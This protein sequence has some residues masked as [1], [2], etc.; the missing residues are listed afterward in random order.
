MRRRIGFGKVWCRA[1]WAALCLLAWSAAAGAKTRESALQVAVTI[2]PQKWLV[3]QVGG[4][5]ATVTALVA[6]G[7]SPATYLP[8]DAQ[9]SR[10]M[11]SAVYFRIGV[12][13]ENGS[14]LDALL[15]SGR[16]EIVDLRDGVELLDMSEHAEHDEAD[17]HSHAGDDP[18]TWLSPSRLKLQAR[19]IAASL[20][21]LDPEG[22]EHY[23]RRLA[24]L[25]RRL[26]DLDAEMHGL[27]AAFAG[28]SFLV[29][30]PS[31]GYLAADYGLRQLTLEI[32]GKEPSE[33]EITELQALA[34]AEGI[35]V[36]FVQPQITGRAAS[37]VASAIDGRTEV[38][39]PLAA[40][41]AANLRQAALRIASSFDPAGSP[42]TEGDGAQ[43]PPSSTHT[44]AS[45]I[46]TSAP[47]ARRGVG[48][49]AF[50]RDAAGNPFLL[51]GL[52]AGLLASLAC[53]IVGPYVVTRR[54]V[55]LGG[56]IAHI[57]VGGLGATI[58]LQFEA[59]EAF[60]GLR[61]LYGA[62]LVAVLAALLLARLE[63]GAERRTGGDRPVAT[64]TVIGALWAA[65]MAI[66]ILLIKLTPGYHTELMSYLFGNLA[67]VDAADVRLILGLDAVI[68]A[69]VLLYQK[70]FLALCLDPEQARLQGVSVRRTSA[71]LLVLVALT[72]ITLTHV[73]GLILVIALLSLPAATASL[74][75]RRLPPM[76]FLSV[77]IAAFLTTVP[78]IAVYGTRVSPEPAIVLAAG[79]LFLSVAAW[80]RW[81]R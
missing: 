70:R 25:E 55:F 53:G 30:H 51:G 50:F 52:W 31:W 44:P 62:A 12:P 49:P 58:F 19:T 23:R 28:R 41:V 77:A 36:V 81:R 71:V 3:E 78:R 16:V 43:L 11:A 42:E 7:D 66:G 46:S 67:Y 29:F 22:A 24:A 61:P 40:D 68:V 75:V 21:R 39:D 79:A 72:V 32:E 17:G 54:I 10:L 59:P 38:L 15:R 74:M 69:T 57:A 63:P 45:P 5:R 60:G 14:W 37:A 27:L 8:S 2:V 65:G 4:E 33:A 73:V 34:R 13:S 47:P 26:D 56:A 48:A 6:P 64:D 35:R 20:T 76:I 1:A 18:H 80:R 9:V